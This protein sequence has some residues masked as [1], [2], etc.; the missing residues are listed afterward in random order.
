MAK[1]VEAASKGV[2]KQLKLSKEK[3]D[4]QNGDPDKRLFALE[5]LNVI[6]YRNLALSRTKHTIDASNVTEKPL[7]LEP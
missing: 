4:N 6:K 7:T 1:P 3:K 2:Q 5:N